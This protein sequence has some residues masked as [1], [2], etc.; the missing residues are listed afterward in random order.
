MKY[1]P[2]VTS[3]RRKQRKALF[4]APNYQRRKLM[5]SPLAKPLKQEYGCRSIP[6]TREDTVIVT[7]GTFKGREGK[8]TA[9]SRS[10]MAVF[11]EK[12]TREKSSGNS[13]N[14]PIKANN[15]RITKLN[16][17]KDRKRILERMNNKNTQKDK[18]DTE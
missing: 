12:C 11:V 5:S 13:H 9:V 7:K 18:M 4:N 1:N 10:Q 17:T 3:S 14:V 6:I 15:V 8:V 2:N 16:L